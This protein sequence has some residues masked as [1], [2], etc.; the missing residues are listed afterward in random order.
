MGCTALRAS[1]VQLMEGESCSQD[2]LKGRLQE[3]KEVAWYLRGTPD[4]SA[5]YSRSMERHG[6]VSW[7]FCYCR[8]RNNLTG[9]FGYSGYSTP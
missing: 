1:P 3:E 6:L 9:V 8:G 2:A 5:A 7:Q 4:R